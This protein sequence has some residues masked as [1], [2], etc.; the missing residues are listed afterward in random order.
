MAG[1]T[2]N[3]WIF[4]FQSISSGCIARAS[5]IIIIILCTAEDSTTDNFDASRW[6]RGVCAD[7][8]LVRDGWLC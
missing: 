7:H 5:C 6:K 3:R 1:G 2:G 4:R 8:S